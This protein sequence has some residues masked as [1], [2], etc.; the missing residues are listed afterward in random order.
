MSAPRP[1]DGALGSC[2]TNTCPEP[3]SRARSQ[4]SP[5]ALLYGCLVRTTLV[6][7]VLAGLGSI[8]ESRSGSPGGPSGLPERDQAGPVLVPQ[9]QAHAAQAP[10]EGQPVDPAQLRVVAHHLAQ[11]VA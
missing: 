9:R 10:P 1:P 8:I 3:G 4:R 11:P 7:S 5:F 2:L 6:S